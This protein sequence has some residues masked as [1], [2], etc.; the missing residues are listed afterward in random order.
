MGTIDIYSDAVA[1]EA[2]S[3]LDTL[4]NICN[5]LHIEK[6][7]K[8]IGQ[9]LPD[10]TYLLLIGLHIL[11]VSKLEWFLKEKG[12][13]PKKSGYGKLQE[14][15]KNS[16]LN[17]LE[18]EWLIYYIELRHLLIH[19]GGRYDRIF[20]NRIKKHNFK[21]LKVEAKEGDLCMLSPEELKIN[22]ELCK[23]IIENI[24]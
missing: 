18:K 23:K 5:E 10:D 12:Y 6:Y 7:P 19:K 3:D 16:Q 24:K 14:F 4:W 13:I 8:T 2:I 22:I 21:H 20:F 9:W 15:I 17:D 11:T 1:D